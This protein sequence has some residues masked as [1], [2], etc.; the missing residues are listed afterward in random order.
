[1]PLTLDPYKSCVCLFNRLYYYSKHWPLLPM[2]EFFFFSFLKK[3]FRTPTPWSQRRRRR[4]RPPW[5]YSPRPRGAAPPAPR[6]GR[7][8][9]SARLSPPSPPPGS[10]GAPPAPC[11]SRAGSAGGARARPPQ[12]HS[13]PIRRKE[14]LLGPAPRG[15]SRRGV[16]G[17]RPP[18]P[19]PSTNQET[20]PRE[21]ARFPSPRT[22]S[23]R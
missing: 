11:H 9:H 5:R 8:T 12:A 2:G 17:F 13:G 19:R 14:R 18:P 22:R 4:R 1:M 16:P 23:H 6:S 7:L 3:D 15:F 20:A 21:R 10:E